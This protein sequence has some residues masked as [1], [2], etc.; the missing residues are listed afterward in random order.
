MQ[1]TK[2]CPKCGNV[3]KAGKSGGQ[4][5]MEIRKQGDFFGESIIPLYC[6]NCGYVEWY[7][8]KKLENRSDP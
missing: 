4:G 1:G 7:I 2:K 3:M 5:L 8:E 6:E